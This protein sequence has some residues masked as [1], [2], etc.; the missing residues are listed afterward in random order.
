M[1][2]KTVLV[3]KLKQ[4]RAETQKRKRSFCQNGKSMKVFFRDVESSCN[5]SSVLEL[6]LGLKTL[7]DSEK[8]FRRKVLESKIPINL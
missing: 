5:E 1:A 2:L 4:L 8:F 3:P 7:L 6:D